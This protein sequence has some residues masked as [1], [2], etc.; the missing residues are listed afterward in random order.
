MKIE[1]KQKGKGEK[2]VRDKDLSMSYIIY[3]NRKAYAEVQK[4]S[5]LFHQRHCQLP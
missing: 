1:M 5:Y 3:S 2:C 4:K